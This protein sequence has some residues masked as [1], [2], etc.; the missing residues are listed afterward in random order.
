MAVLRISSRPNDASGPRSKRAEMRT[1]AN[2]GSTAL[3]CAGPFVSGFKAGGPAARSVTCHTCRKAPRPRARQ[4]VTLIELLV[5]IAIV[6]VVLAMLLSAVQAVREASNRVECQVRLR[7]L[8]IALQSY[9]HNFGRFPEGVGEATPGSPFPF[10]GWQ[11]WLLPYVG[12]ETLAVVTEEAYRREPLFYDPPHVGLKTPVR[13]FVCPSDGR[14]QKAQ[15]VHGHFVAFTSYLG[16]EGTDLYSNDGVLYQGSRVAIADVSDGVSN[17]LLVGERPPSADLA[18]GWWYAGMGQAT[19]GS[20]DMVLGARELNSGFSLLRMCERGPAEFGPGRLSNQCDALHFWS[21]HRGGA[22]FLY[23]DGSVHFLT[24]DARTVLPALA[25]R[26]GS[27]A[28]E[29]P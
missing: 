8:G 23:V 16:V 19:T 13:G 11:T 24:Y 12:Q 7:E 14:V 25:T 6:A 2:L 21:V 22:N 5:V 10:R 15:F 4:A 1:S 17:T 3:G 18:F 29:A 9:H 20:C 28:L 27:E 26:Q